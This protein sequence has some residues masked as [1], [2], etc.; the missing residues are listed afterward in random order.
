MTFICFVVIS[1]SVLSF[2]DFSAKKQE[3]CVFLPL[4]PKPC[5]LGGY[6]ILLI[7]H[8]PKDMEGFISCYSIYSHFLVSAHFA[9]VWHCFVIICFTVHLCIYLL[10]IFANLSCFGAQISYKQNDYWKIGC[11]FKIDS[12]HSSPTQNHS[13]AHMHTITHAYTHSWHV[14]MPAN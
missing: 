14:T 3:A 13:L 6:P 5:S 7:V 10:N 8:W 2:S 4:R 12:I 11:I 1:T 9:L